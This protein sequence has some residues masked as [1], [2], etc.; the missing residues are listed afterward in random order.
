DKRTGRLAVPAKDLAIPDLNFQLVGNY[1]FQTVAVH[2]RNRDP[3]LLKFTD[4]PTPPAPPVQ[5]IK[6]RVV[7][8]KRASALSAVI[9]ALGKASS[10]KPARPG[11]DDD[12]FEERDSTDDTE[13][14]EDE[15]TDPFE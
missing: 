11:D 8:K 5:V 10:G 3:L 14:F 1:Q 13:L 6:K 12:L 7:K 15:K 2:F 9:K 4:Q